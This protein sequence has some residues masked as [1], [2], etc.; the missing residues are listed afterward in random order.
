[1]GV[2]NKK[3]NIGNSVKNETV[4]V[5]VLEEIS[6]NPTLFTRMYRPF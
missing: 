6:M 3:R 5:T 1:M 2:A 4:Q